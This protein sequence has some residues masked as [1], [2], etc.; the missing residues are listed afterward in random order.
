MEKEDDVKDTMKE[1]K[2]DK[3]T[4]KM[5]NPIMRKGLKGDD[6]AELE[7]EKMRD[8]EE[9]LDEI[10]SELEESEKVNEDARTDAEEEGYEDG[11]E[12]EKE[13][14][15]GDEAEEIDLE[16]MTDDD[17]K[18]F[19]EDV[20][21]DM[22]TAG[23]IEA[24][25]NFE[26]EVDVDVDVD[27]EDE[28]EVEDEVTDVDVEITETK[29]PVKEVVGVVAG[30]AALVG[31]AGGLSAI[32]MA[33]DNPETRSKYPKLAA[34][35]DMMGEIGSAASRAKLREDESEK[36]TDEEL[37]KLES[38]IGK[39][40]EGKSSYEEDDSSEL[41]EAYTTIETLREDLNEINLLNAKLLYTNKIFKSKN[42]NENDKVKV[43][44]NFDKATTIKEAK[45]IYD[46]LIDLKPKG[47]KSIK[48]NLGR[49]SKSTGIAPKKNNPQPIIES[50]QMIDR[51][52]KLAGII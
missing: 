49:A 34:M 36:A 46:T 32:E 48:E 8:V 30:M 12:D 26:D 28:V 29:E 51:F 4:E 7:T 1:A 47:K 52:K 20:I 13:D 40:F 6:P 10:L 16:D 50:S 2:N 41:N 23:E 45:L 33:M 22:V 44:T 27:V 37:G 43:L 18:K 9:N 31:A 24:G 5:T 35:L 38:E 19:I 14:L 15:E 25:E 21:E 39:V 17:L 11:M 42:L 3:I